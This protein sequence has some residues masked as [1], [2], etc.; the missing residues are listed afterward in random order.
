MQNDLDSMINYK[1]DDEQYTPKML[2][3]APK[4]H[5]FNKLSN[6]GPQIKRDLIYIL[7]WTYGLIIR[8]LETLQYLTLKLPLSGKNGFRGVSKCYMIFLK[9]FRSF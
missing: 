7:I 3:L 9:Q 2:V 8:V 1:S 4:S 5:R 6:S